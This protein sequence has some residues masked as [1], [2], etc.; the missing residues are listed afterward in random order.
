MD[1]VVNNTWSL[2]GVPGGVSN[3]IV[4]V[5]RQRQLNPN[6]NGYWAENYYNA[7]GR[8]RSGVW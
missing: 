7:M 4:M 2:R 5:S 6:A 3:L 8:N 1:F